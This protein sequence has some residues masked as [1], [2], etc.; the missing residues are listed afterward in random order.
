MNILDTIINAQDGGAVRQLG[1]QFGLG[2]EQTTSALSALLPALAAGL[3]QNMSSPD[4]LSRLT[5]A[6]AS[7]Q[8]QSHLENPGSLAEPSTIADGNNILGHLLGSKDASRT[9]ASDAASQ[10]GLS[11]DVIKQMLPIAAAM[12]MGA[13]ARHSAAAVG[14]AGT[15]ASSSLASLLTPLLDSNRDGSMMD[16]VTGMIGKFIGRA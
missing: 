5:Q 3:Q 11:P 1:S 8:H 7:G 9:V 12:L 10:T 6:L 15:P 13:A 4:G 16:D 14:T 2:A